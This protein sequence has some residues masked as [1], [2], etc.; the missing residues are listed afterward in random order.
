MDKDNNILLEK[1]FSTHNSP[2]EKV[3]KVSKF[4]KFA[5]QSDFES[6]L[7]KL[8]SESGTNNIPS[9][10]NLVFESF[11][12]VKLKLS[13]SEGYTHLYCNIIGDYEIEA[14]QVHFLHPRPEVSLYENASLDKWTSLAILK[15]GT[16]TALFRI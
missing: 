15:R 13:H 16:S 2:Y 10:Y 14:S 5:D 8:Y 1:Y 3:N 12:D 6:K 11:K 9:I 4:T 7:L